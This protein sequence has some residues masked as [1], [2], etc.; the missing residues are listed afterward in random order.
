V[1][2]D[3]RNE[4]RRGGVVGIARSL[5]VPHPAPRRCWYRLR[6]STASAI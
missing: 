2:A 5:P 3:P 6:H 4:T 1:K